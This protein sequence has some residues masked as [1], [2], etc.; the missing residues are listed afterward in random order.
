MKILTVKQAP[1]TGRSVASR[2]SETRCVSIM[3]L[4]SPLIQTD[5][6]AVGCREEEQGGDQECGKEGTEIHERTARW[7]CSM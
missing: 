4:C 3:G 7:V 2:Y 1:T 5:H 6:V